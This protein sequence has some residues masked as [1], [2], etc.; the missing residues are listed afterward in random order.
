MAERM[1]DDLMFDHAD[2]L[3]DFGFK[4]SAFVLPPEDLLVRAGW[5]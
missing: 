4:P 5:W 1:N 2:A 3:R